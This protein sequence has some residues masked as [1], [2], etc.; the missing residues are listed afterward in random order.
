MFKRLKD[1]LKSWSESFSKKKESEEPAEEE[2]QG[3]EGSESES[4]S[5]ASKQDKKVVADP[6]ESSEKTLDYGSDEYEDR[7]DE[8][9]E[10][11][12][13]AGKEIKQVEPEKKWDVAQHQFVPDLDK[14]E[15]K[16]EKEAK[17]KSSEEEKEKPKK[18]GFFKRLTS[19]TVSITEEEFDKHSED[20]EMLLMENNVALEVSEQIIEKLKERVVGS[21]VSK[22]E[23]FSEISSKLKEVIEEVLVEPFDLVEKVKNRQD[24]SS[25]YV[26]MFC[27]VNGTG[28]T[29]SI[30]KVAKL[31]KEEGLSCVIAASDTF[32]AASIEQLKKHGENLDVGVVANE[33]GSD[34][35]SVAY[36]AINNAKSQGK[37]CVLIDTAG[38]M[39]TEKNLMSQVEKIARVSGPDLKIFVGESTTGND[40]VEQVRAFD[41]AVGVDGIILSKADTDEKGGTA[42][43]VGETTG[44]PILYLGLGQNYEDL[45]KF[46]REKFVEKLGLYEFL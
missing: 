39:H 36:D 26:V 22:K 9:L 44:K 17:E 3:K 16:I 46:D 19:G 18:K 29:T 11:S 27:G 5:E 43:S 6:E 10:E 2:V 28:K 14:T 30:A 42:L 31:L 8:V 34:P 40:I 25:P 15:E 20:L 33:Y 35:A 38:R 41:E 37:D 24:T 32:R 45:E 7:L 4:F 23:V 21:E 1:R 13:K 12:E